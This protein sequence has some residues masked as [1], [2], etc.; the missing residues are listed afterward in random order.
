MLKLLSIVLFLNLSFSEGYNTAINL[1]SYRN[2]KYEVDVHGN[3]R[4]SYT[5]FENFIS[6]ENFKNRNNDLI[7]LSFYFQGRADFSVALLPFNRQPNNYETIFHTCK[8]F[9][10]L[11]FIL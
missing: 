10:C 8:L 9:C 3:G 5:E 11:Y 7:R 4:K 2:C 1:N 6:I